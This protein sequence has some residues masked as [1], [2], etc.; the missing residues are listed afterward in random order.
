MQESGQP[1]TRRALYAALLVLSG[2][3]SVSLVATG[4]D[5]PPV[6]F[7]IPAQ[8]LAGALN[9]WAV[10]ANAQVFF[11]QS[12]VEGL[13][14]PAVTGSLPA[15]DALRA[16]LAHTKL[17][18]VQNEQGAFVIRRK[19]VVAHHSPAPS[20][21]PS[22][23][24]TVQAEQ[25]QPAARAPTAR[26]L[27][28]AWVIR[29]RGVYLYPRQGSD[30]LQLSTPRPVVVP[31]DATRIDGGWFP[32][33]DLEYFFTSRW[34][35]ELAVG[36]PSV[37]RLSLRDNAFASGSLG[38]F[39]YLPGFATIKYNL[40][41]EGVLRPYVGL[42]LNWTG[43]FDVNATPYELSKSVVSPV[44]QV[45]FDFSLGHRWVLN[46]DL[47]WAR[48]HSAVRYD[49]QLVGQMRPEPLFFAIGVGYRFGAV[50]APPAAFSSL[51]IA[52]RVAPSPPKCP[53]TPNGIPVDSDGC[54][55]DSDG[56]GVPDYLDKCPGT[57]TGVKVDA[58]G[59]EVQEWVLRGVSFQTNSATLDP[60]SFHVLDEVVALLARR[61]DA[62]VEIR[63]YTDS[64]GTDSYNL[65]LS[66]RR[67]ASVASYLRAHG[68]EPNRLSSSGFGKLN[69]VAGNDTDAG[70]AQNRRVTV[71][72][73][74]PM[75]R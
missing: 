13:S 67:A 37:H 26:D 55:L 69:P 54:P 46:A 2:N 52:P 4:A 5:E 15:K 42:G 7:D 61:S 34:S 11:E 60:Q 10:Q 25:S 6:A 53:N 21:R 63:G 45:G 39:R 24:P 38:D 14:A 1:G 44:A 30:A 17:E 19:H 8:P 12:P 3:L 35:G 65:L 41:P 9:T 64:R 40:N 75:L 62:K 48:I 29:L 47:K 43:Y 56:D 73:E 72:F 70:R 66:E 33:L 22:A 27:E 32:E 49:E 58:N 36:L 20:P 57:P 59:C 23:G 74:Q 68:I 71:R 31:Q 51:Q 16:L 50:D 28:G 18:Y